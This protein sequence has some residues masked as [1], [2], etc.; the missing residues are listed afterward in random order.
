MTQTNRW[1]IEE[2]CL[3]EV[4]EGDLELPAGSYIVSAERSNMP[5]GW[6]LIVAIY[7]GT[8]RR[9]PRCKR[10]GHAGHL[11]YPCHHKPICTCGAMTLV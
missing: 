4:D 3:L 9:K 6:L 1:R 8:N 10:C 7:Q 11:P 5:P 2:W